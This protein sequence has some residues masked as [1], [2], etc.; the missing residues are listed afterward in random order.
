MGKVYHS[1]AFGDLYNTYNFP[2]RASVHTLSISMSM[3][4]L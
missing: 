4:S 3:L 2:D 1:F